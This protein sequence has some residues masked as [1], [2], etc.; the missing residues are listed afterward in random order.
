MTLID[1]LVITD[2][3]NITDILTD[4]LL[5]VN[6]VQLM[7]RILYHFTVTVQAKD[8][9]VKRVKDIAKSTSINDSEYN[10]TC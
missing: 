8:S 2:T 9:T 3:T 4:L 5:T 7:E 10:N 6:D 1:T